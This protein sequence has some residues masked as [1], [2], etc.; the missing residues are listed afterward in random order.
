METKNLAS[1]ACTSSDRLGHEIWS[2]PETTVDLEL[3]VL[4][5]KVHVVC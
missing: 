5:K 2:K 4:K 1:S 3:M